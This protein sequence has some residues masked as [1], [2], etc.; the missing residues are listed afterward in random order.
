MQNKARPVLGKVPTLHQRSSTGI[1][2]DGM[3]VQW[4]T[5]VL[6]GLKT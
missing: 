6:S 5:N 2:E 1:L 4:H 3:W